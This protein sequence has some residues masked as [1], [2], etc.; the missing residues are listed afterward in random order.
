[1]LGGLACREQELRYQHERQHAFP[2]IHASMFS[3]SPKCAYP[4]ESEGRT[5]S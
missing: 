1:L 3:P 4:Q 5:A 2:G